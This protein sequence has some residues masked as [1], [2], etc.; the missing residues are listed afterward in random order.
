LRKIK[1]VSSTQLK[2]GGGT[3][4][5]FLIII[6]VLTSWWDVYETMI[7]IA[8]MVEQP[9]IFDPTRVNYHPT[10]PGIS[11]FHPIPERNC[12]A[13]GI[14]GKSKTKKIKFSSFLSIY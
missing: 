13:A 8:K 9:H 10:T 4:I 1:E 12:S 2:D 3:E 6:I 11:L 5:R 7:N 14:P